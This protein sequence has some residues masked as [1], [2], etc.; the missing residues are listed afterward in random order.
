MFTN[1][2]KR[3]LVPAVVHSMINNVRGNLEQQDSVDRGLL[4]PKEGSRLQAYQQTKRFTREQ[5]G[6]GVHAVIKFLHA[7]VGRAGENNIGSFFKSTEAQKFMSR[8]STWENHTALSAMEQQ[9][10]QNMKK[11]IPTSTTR[12]ASQQVSA[13][14]RH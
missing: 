7:L 8:P 6:Y 2:V 1:P 10:W 3:V 11:T 12:L 14:L 9:A 5:V 4:Q 13:L